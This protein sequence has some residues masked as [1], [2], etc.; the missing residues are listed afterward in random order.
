[1]SNGFLADVGKFEAYT[2]PVIPPVTP[3]EVPVDPTIELNRQIEVLKLE[4]KGLAEA[5]AASQG[6]VKTLSERNAFLEETI[7]LR[8]TELKETEIQLDRITDERDRFEKEKNELLLIGTV[9]SATTGRL[10]A[11]LWKRITK[12][13]RVQ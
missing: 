9:T 13:K 12:K 2:P 4:N 3:P 10:F 11:E 1:M 7:I 5:L 6:Q 8:D